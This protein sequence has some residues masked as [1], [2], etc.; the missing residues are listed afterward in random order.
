MTTLFRVVVAFLVAAAPPGGKDPDPPKVDL[1]H[2]VGVWVIAKGDWPKGSTVEFRK[3][4]TMTI[5]IQTPGLGPVPV[6]GKYK[7]AGK[8]KLDTTTYDLNGTADK[9][10][11]EIKVLTAKRLVIAGEK[12]R[13]EEFTRKE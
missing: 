10:T 8:T 12:G 1:K 3:D 7:A 5:T 6:E 9:G 11:M 4:G 13:D 2:L